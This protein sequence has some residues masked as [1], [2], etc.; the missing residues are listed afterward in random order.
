MPMFKKLEWYL[1]LQLIF[2]VLTIFTASF[3]L[4]KGWYVYAFL[5]AILIIYIVNYIY[6]S[7]IKIYRELKQFA[8]AIKYRDF[9][10]HFNSSHSSP[11]LQALR[12][13]F[14]ELNAQF[15]N[16][17]REKETQ[18]Q[19]L[20]QILEMVDTGILSYETQSGEVLWM[21]ES[22]K[23][24]LGVPYLKLIH[25]FAKRD[26]ELYS[27]ITSLKPGESKIGTVQGMKNPY[28][29]LLS[30]SSFSTDGKKYSLVAFQ[31]INEA[32]DETEAKAWQKLLSV[33]THEIMNSIAPIS[34]LA[35]TIKNSVVSID[36][37]KYPAGFLEDLELGISTIKN[38][39]EGLFRFAETYRNLNKI[40]RPD[41]KTF[42]VRDLFENLFNLMQPTLAEKNIELDIIL[43]DP[44][45]TL[46]ADI[47]LI[48]QLMI[49][50]LLNAIDAVKE[51]SEPQISLSSTIDM[52]GKHLIKVSDNG[53]GMSEDV[54]DKIF[55]P[56][57]STKK[58]GSG[59][60]LTLC[61]QIMMLHNGNLTVQS[62]QGE[63]A[64]FILK[65]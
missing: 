39:S 47:N 42:Y 56:F 55:V 16:V 26:K 9:S 24:M 46:E 35:E 29:V 59:I 19:Y 3:C 25:S 38:R 58:S 13:G 21:N 65:F 11:A 4:L 53:T 40:S 43:K 37:E 50:L 12:K 8:E 36:K 64:I 49:N 28:K 34:S 57:F 23:K 22:L 7:Q 6:T 51:V 31:N 1:L 30:A 17:S 45:L 62:K 32:L 63:G 44:A 10:R 52:D 15:R 2:L 33:L 5:T 14:N 54:L 61:K 20:H 48:E 27:E 18:Y 41:L 60:G